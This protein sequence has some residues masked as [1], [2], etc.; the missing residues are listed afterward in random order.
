[1][2]DS[3]AKKINMVIRP[4]RRAFIAGLGSAA[5]WPVVA[6][7]QQPAKIARVGFL[8][9]APAA[10]WAN[11]VEALRAGLRDLGSREKTS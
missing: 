1:V 6:R 2:T 11:E 10:A 5:A 4:S 3:Q 8:N 7:G 9:L